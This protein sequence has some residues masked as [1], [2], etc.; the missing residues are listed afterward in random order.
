MTYERSS[1]FKQTAV[2]Q[3]L[4]TAHPTLLSRDEI[5][6]ELDDQIAADDALETFRR[7]GLVHRLTTHDG[8]F[9]WATR[10]AM[11][12]EEAVTGPALSD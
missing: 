1:D 9:F 3:I 10:A 5:R 8:D 4:L 6:R 12:A 2:M 7:A 11:A